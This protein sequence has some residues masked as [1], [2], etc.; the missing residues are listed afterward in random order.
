MTK[1]Q[2]YRI[3]D[4]NI[5]QR[6]F[7]NVDILEEKKVM[8]DLDRHVENFKDSYAKLVFSLKECLINLDFSS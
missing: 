3:Y 5:S 4:N 6:L 7:N 8:I 1:S 2:I